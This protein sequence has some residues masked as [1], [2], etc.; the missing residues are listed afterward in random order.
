MRIRVIKWFADVCGGGVRALGR[1]WSGATTCLGLLVVV[2]LQTAPTSSFGQEAI[3][4]FFAPGVY[5]ADFDMFYPFGIDAAD[6]MGP[7]AQNNDPDGYP[8]IALA[9]GQI[10][11]PL[12]F[13]TDYTGVPGKVVVFR[14]TQVW[15]PTNA[16]LEIATSFDLPAETAPGEI[17]WA[18]M[19]NDGWL[20]LVIAV[21]TPFPET[22]TGSGPWGIYVYER[23]ASPNEDVQFNLRSFLPTD[24]PVRGLTI[25]DFNNDGSLDAA[26]ATDYLVPFD[27]DEP[28]EQKDRLFVG[29]NDGTG[30]L[31]QAVQWPIE[32][33]EPDGQSPSDLVAGTFDLTPGL[34]SLPDL[35]ATSSS[36]T[37]GSF[38]N[39]LTNLGAAD[40]S[41]TSVLPNCP[42]LDFIDVERGRLSFGARSDDA[43][44]VNS[45]G[46]LFVLHGDGNGGF[47]H[48]CSGV[49]PDDIYLE[50]SGSPLTFRWS[51]VDVGHLNG[52]TKQD[53]VVVQ[54][55]SVVE[56][57]VGNGDGTLTYTD[58]GT[59]THP[60]GANI[61]MR[62][63]LADM[64]QDGFD[65]IV[66]SNHGLKDEP[67]T[68][69]VLINKMVST[70]P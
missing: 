64:N 63:V 33:T 43:I 28:D 9:V 65:D 13:V 42:V 25:A 4:H 52:G 22:F 57:L 54:G 29:L 59:Y 11:I 62:V 60:T 68:V 7:T 30:V 27:P 39:S 8:D 46:W 70:L 35:V 49:E 66:T 21:S 10:H 1:A 55:Q 16:G 41:I 5:Q 2:S 15:S 56:V 38:V 17:K 48:D 36:Y 51:G 24:L 6:V 47:T 58:T 34:T 67:A 23:V 18:D 12:G 3:P 40:F 32:L 50:Q 26:A 31:S 19:T 61:A 45:N 37:G 14:N 69:S 53:V 44:G 20:D